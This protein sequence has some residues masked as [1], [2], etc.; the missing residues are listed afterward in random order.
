[1][2]AITDQCYCP[3]SYGPVSDLTTPSI[4]TNIKLTRRCNAIFLHP[5]S[6]LS[7]GDPYVIKKVKTATKK[8]Q[9]VKL[10]YCDV[11]EMVT[12]NGCTYRQLEQ[13][14]QNNPKIALASVLEN[15]YILRFL[16][17]HFKSDYRYSV[18]ALKRDGLLLKYLPLKNRVWLPC[19]TAIHSN[20]WSLEFIPLDIQKLYPSLIRLAVSYDGRVVQHASKFMEKP[21]GGSDQEKQE[22]TIVK[23]AIEA[24]QQNSRA[25][26]FLPQYLQW[27]ESIAKAALEIDGMLFKDLPEH[28]QRE[29]GLAQIAYNQNPRVVK[30]FSEYMRCYVLSKTSGC[31]C[32]T[33]P[34]LDNDPTFSEKLYNFMTSWFVNHS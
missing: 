20:P 18:P 8:E 3:T 19:V 17:Q 14:W 28:C 12:K 15:P 24:I 32:E 33:S 30:H 2:L 11:L 13:K 27:K 7:K 31:G 5:P 25:Y 4:P 29:P 9:T 16:P 26:Y 10:T 1:M 21:K 6:D 34:T 23:I 22:E